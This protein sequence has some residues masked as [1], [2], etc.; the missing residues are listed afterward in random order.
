MK[1]LQKIFCSAETCNYGHCCF[2]MD[3]AVHLLLAAVTLYHN[4]RTFMYKEMSFKKTA[5]F[6]GKGKINLRFNWKSTQ[7][8]CMEKS[9]FNCD[10]AE[11]SVHHYS[12]TFCCTNTHTH[13]EINKTHSCLHK[14]SDLH[15]HMSQRFMSKRD[16]TCPALPQNNLKAKPCRHYDNVT[17]IKRKWNLFLHSKYLKMSRAAGISLLSFSSHK[18]ASKH[19][20]SLSC[21]HISGNVKFHNNIKLL[22][23]TAYNGCNDSQN[24]ELD[25]TRKEF[26]LHLQ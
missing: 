17:V 16:H 3:L 8:F 2:L 6:H 24:D 19:M 9:V 20:V 18:G 13:T 12:W 14:Y 21:V 7:M 4:Q 15:I 25:C 10:R 1:R 22:P 11:P 26:S 5:Q 23:L